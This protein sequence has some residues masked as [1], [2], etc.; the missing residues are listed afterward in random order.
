MSHTRIAL[1]LAMLSALAGCGDADDPL[2]EPDPGTGVLRIGEEVL[3]FEVITCGTAGE[4]DEGV[5][6]LAGRG[7]TGAGEPFTVHATRNDVGP[8]HLHSVSYRA[9][10]VL[11]GVGTILEAQRIR[12]GD[13]WQSPRGGPGEPLI[14]VDGNVVS[15]SGLF[16][17][18]EMRSDP[19]PGALRAICD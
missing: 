15:V 13:A 10:N 5:P 14:R 3:S 19:I 12:D 16:S 11:M 1:L 6:T 17:E 2:P 4:K 9:G 8:V 7:T 18:P